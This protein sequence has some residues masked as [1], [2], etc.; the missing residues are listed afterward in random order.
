MRLSTS[1]L[2]RSDIKSPPCPVALTETEQNKSDKKKRQS[3]P[4]TTAI[5]LQY[6]LQIKEKNHHPLILY[7]TP[8]L[9]HYTPVSG[10]ENTRHRRVTASSGETQEWNSLRGKRGW[11]FAVSFSQTSSINTLPSYLNQH[12]QTGSALPLLAPG[13]PLCV[14]APMQHT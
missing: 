8:N 6:C 3:E 9:S 11:A 1:L 7:H 13:F 14:S 4:S 12:A 10:Q 5:R 2:K